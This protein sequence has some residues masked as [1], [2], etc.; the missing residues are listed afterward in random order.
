MKEGDIIVINNK[1][2]K[3]VRNNANS[4]IGYV[5]GN[6]SGGHSRTLC[7]IHRHEQ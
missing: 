4:C 5:F 1:T 7:Y 2:Y 3:A 6:L